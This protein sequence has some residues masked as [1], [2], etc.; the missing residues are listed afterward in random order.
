MRTSQSQ[1]GNRTYGAEGS[2]AD[3]TAS[4]GASTGAA[5]APAAGAGALAAL[6]PQPTNVVSKNNIVTVNLRYI[7]PPENLYDRNEI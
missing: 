4:T 7:N 1:E 3:L 6:S 2:S 5:A